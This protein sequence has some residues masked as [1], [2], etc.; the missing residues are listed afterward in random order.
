[1]RR[2]RTL[3][4]CCL[5]FGLLRATEETGAA[6]KNLSYENRN[7]TDYGPL[8]VAAVRGFAKDAQGVVIPKACVGVFTE[9]GHKL[10]ATTRTDDD[11]RFRLNDIPDGD[12]RLIAKY[13]GF[14][15]ANAK[16]RI[17]Q[18][19]QSKKSLTVQMRPTGLDTQSFI[20]L[21]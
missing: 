20:E 14:S 2:G 16:L 19:L 12:Y 7:Q 21:R 17:E 13:E 10:V 4:I 8:H 6:C 11:G 5:A 15:P 18:R 3:A 9:V 1:M